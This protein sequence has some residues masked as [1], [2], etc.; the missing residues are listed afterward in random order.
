MTDPVRL[1]KR[2]AEQLGCSRR[3]AELYIE[4]GWVNVDGQVVEAPFRKIEPG[5][6]IELRAGATATEIAP[7]TLLLHRPAGQ[8]AGT[9]AESTLR[10]LTAATHCSEDPSRI[11][12]LQR[13]L[14]RQNELLPLEADSSGL[15]VFSQQREVIRTLSGSRNKFEQEYIVDVSGEPEANGLALLAK[16]IGHRGRILPKAKVSW[17]SETRLRVVLKEPAPGEVRML[18]EAIGLR[19]LAS[20]RIR[21]G[22]LSMAK[23]PAGQWRYLGEHERF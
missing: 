15:V 7:V 23:L 6:R 14:L 3:E 1:S 21:I 10:M 2:L 5:Q 22:R 17:Q 16:G 12:P 18:C 19:V 8:A 13:H 20:K 4:G 11:E 9:D